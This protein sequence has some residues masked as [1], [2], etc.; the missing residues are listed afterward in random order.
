MQ[1][2]AVPDRGSRCVT[3]V[4]W[5]L[6]DTRR[7]NSDDRVAE[8]D[9]EEQDDR[10]TTRCCSGRYEYAFGKGFRSP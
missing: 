9:A 2:P 5:D 7:A 4:Q 6:H 10:A 8:F 3:F 1:G